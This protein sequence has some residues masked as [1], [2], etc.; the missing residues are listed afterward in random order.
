MTNKFLLSIDGGGVKCIST[1]QLLFCIE[2]ILGHTIYDT[3]DMFAGT[4]SGALIVS[5]IAYKKMSSE[6]VRQVF[7]YENMK[8]LFEKSLNPLKYIWLRPLY[9]GTGKRNLIKSF[10]ND[11]NIKD[12]EKKCLITGYSATDKIPLFFKSYENHHNSTLL[13]ALDISTAVPGYFPPVKS[14]EGPAESFYGIDGGMFAMNPTDCMYVDFIKLL[15]RLETSEKDSIR[16][17]SI[18]YKDSSVPTIKNPSVW[19]K[20]QWLIKGDVIDI[21][22]SA[23]PNIVDYRMNVLTNSFGHKYLRILIDT[24]TSSGD[25]CSKKDYD[26]LLNCGLKSFK[27]NQN[28]LIEFFSQ[29]PNP[30]YSSS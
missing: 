26:D 27:D 13:D 10:A 29:I 11:M 5:S 25:G 1:I 21:L 14:E 4:S 24:G 30:N 9:T 17:L 22:S 23:N 3:F 12:T 19:G 8:K 20:I 6:Q 2:H 7:S 28:K 18:G 15:S 16:I